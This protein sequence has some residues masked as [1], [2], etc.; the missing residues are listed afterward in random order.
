MPQRTV[1][2]CTKQ[3]FTSR[4]MEE[5]GA[6]LGNAWPRLIHAVNTVWAFLN[7]SVVKFENPL[8]NSPETSAHQHASHTSHGTVM[9][10]TSGF[11]FQFLPPCPLLEHRGPYACTSEFGFSEQSA[12]LTEQEVLSFPE[13]AADCDTCRPNMVQRTYFGMSPSISS[14]MLLL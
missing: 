4:W 9:L 8:C 7:E 14:S 3:H 11:L 5:A 13:H 12:E 10:G 2:S 6:W 1:G